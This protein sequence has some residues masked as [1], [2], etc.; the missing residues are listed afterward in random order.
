MH[1]FIFYFSLSFSLS[2]S[3]SLYLS[4]Y[5]SIYLYLFFSF[6][7]SRLGRKCQSATDVKGRSRHIY[8]AIKSNIAGGAIFVFARSN[9]N[10]WEGLGV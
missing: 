10:Q 7:L 6:S 2:L 8:Y 9:E 5:L 1:S 3:L 4:I